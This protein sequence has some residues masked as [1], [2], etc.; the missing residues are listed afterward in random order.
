VHPADPAVID[1]F[2]VR[3]THPARIAERHDIQIG[4]VVG[5]LKRR[6]IRPLLAK[7]EIGVDFYR[8][9]DIEPDFFT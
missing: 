1:D 4:A 2:K 5:R 3:L 6:G 7:A 9:S 8:T